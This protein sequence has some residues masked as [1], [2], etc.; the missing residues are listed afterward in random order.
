VLVCGGRD[1]AGGVARAFEAI[2]HPLGLDVATLKSEGRY[3][4][5]VY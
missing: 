2:L 5:D 3:R 1:V 4:E